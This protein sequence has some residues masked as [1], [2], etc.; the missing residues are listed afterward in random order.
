MDKQGLFTYIV[1]IITSD[2]LVIEGVRA[3]AAVILTKFSWNCPV[4]VPVVLNTLHDN[5]KMIM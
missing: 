4:L 2:A 5:K 1:K 3:S